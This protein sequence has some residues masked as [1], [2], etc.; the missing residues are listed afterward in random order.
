VESYSATNPEEPFVYRRGMIADTETALPGW[1]IGIDD[2][3]EPD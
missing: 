2:I 3:S 1:Q